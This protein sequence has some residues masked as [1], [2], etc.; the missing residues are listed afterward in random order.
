MMSNLVCCKAVDLPG[1]YVTCR[2][3]GPRAE[4]PW[5]VDSQEPI[6]V[7]IRVRQP[8]EAALG[9]LQLRSGRPAFDRLPV[10]TLLDCYM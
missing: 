7:R 2:T 10:G 9:S 4:R 8:D 1:L 6:H 5:S 3:R